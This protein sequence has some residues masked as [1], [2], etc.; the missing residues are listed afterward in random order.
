MSSALHGPKDTLYTVELRQDQWDLIV[1]C[2]SHVRDMTCSGSSA[3][4]VDAV[5]RKF[6]RRCVDETI[7]EIRA[8]VPERK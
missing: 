1:Y 8:D 6:L 2:L 7:K 3:Y 5:C 4:A